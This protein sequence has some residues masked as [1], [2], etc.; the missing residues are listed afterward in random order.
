[1]DDGIASYLWE[2][3]GGPTVVLSG[4]TGIQTTFD[5]PQEGDDGMSL[6][7][8]LTVTD[9]GGLQSAD[10]CIVNVSSL[11][12]PPVANAGQD[13]SVGEGTTVT[14]DGAHSTDS[15]DGI[16]SYLWTQT[17][18]VP[19]TLSVTT[20]VRPTF[21]A[22]PV[23][24]QGD[25]LTF[26]LTVTD[27]GGLQ[28]GDDVSVSIDDN[29]IVIFPEAA[30]TLWTSEN[31]EMG[32][33]MADGGDCTRL[34]AVDASAIADMTNRPDDLIYGLISME[35][36]THM[37]GG[38]VNVTIHLPEPAPAGYR[39]YKFGPGW[40][41][42]SDH[43]VFNAHRT[44]VTLHLVDGGAGD[45]DGMPNGVIVD[46]LGLGFAPVAPAAPPA[47]ASARTSVGDSGGGGGGGCFI[48]SACHVSSCGICPKALADAMYLDHLTKTFQKLRFKISTIQKKVTLRN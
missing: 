21:V 12:E 30:M 17:G 26:Q 37:I 29:G 43:A 27:H 8:R 18:G 24:A 42:Y 9:H 34:E 36:K 7:F 39:W 2:Q 23:G 46:P 22:P 10:T 48:A 3:I 45:E 47:P 1:L 35:I 25:E 40:Y 20:A 38:S 14:L 32:V 33:E 13:R 4:D 6:T 44:R 31:Q 41:D 28:A 5:A 15:D 16:A 11:N 19:V